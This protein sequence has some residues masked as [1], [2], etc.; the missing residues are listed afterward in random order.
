MFKSIDTFLNKIT[1]YK[2]VLYFLLGL[3]AIAMLLSWVGVLPYNPLGL[4]FSALFITT[5]CLLVNIIFSWAF[6]APTNTESVYITAL[7]LVLIITPIASVHDVPFFILG[8]WAS[9]WA[10]ASKYIFAIKKKHVFNPV[11]FAVVVTALTLAQSASWWVGT[12]WMTP[13]VIVGG[14]MVTRKII[15]FDL[16]VSFFVVAIAVTL[17]GL[18]FVGIA[19]ILSNFWRLLVGTPLLFFACIMLTEPLTTPPS[20]WLRI[21]Y[22]AMVGL[23]F[24]PSVHI[25]SLYLTPELALVI[26]NIFSYMVSSKQKLRLRLLERIPITQDSYDFVFAADQKLQFK[27]GQYLEWTLDRSGVDSRGNRRYFTISSSPTEKHIAMGIKFYSRSSTFK[28][29]LLSM[30]RGGTLMASQL[31]GDFVLPRDKKK[32]LVFIAGG[33]GITPFRSMIKYL[34]DTNDKRD[35]VLLCSNK[36]KDDI[37][38]KEVFDQAVE[39]LGIKV[40]YAITDIASPDYNGIIDSKK[41]QTEVPDYKERYFYLSGPRGLVVGFEENLKKLGIRESHIKTDFFPGLV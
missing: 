18:P 38:Y 39:Q 29:H 41:I 7:I 32:K 35:V 16:V 4:L 14:L 26:G 13:F 9:I 12:L 24:A 17:W 34:I 15:R 21:L 10:M 1:M 28:T 30:K 36:T 40:M 3:I 25:G 37:A 23:L 31:A 19:D 22:G 6:N 11:A 5:I 33:I 20:R 27:P 8:A 2:L